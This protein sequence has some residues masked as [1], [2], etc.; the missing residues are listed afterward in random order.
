MLSLGYCW[1][2]CH[3]WD[4]SCAA[5]WYM[6]PTASPINTLCWKRGGGG[7][8]LVPCWKEFFLLYITALHRRNISGSG[9]RE[10]KRAVCAATPL[11]LFPS[12]PAH[13]SLKYRSPKK[14]TGPAR[15]FSQFF[16]FFIRVLRCGCFLSSEFF[17]LFIG[18]H[19]FPIGYVIPPSENQRCAV[20][21][22]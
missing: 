10:I 4:L 20:P 11:R 16:S 17:A 6:L 14:E 2:L 1:P 22:F 18:L 13:V 15:L 9:E 21:M 8:G 5:G 12:M 7:G 3:V 19:K